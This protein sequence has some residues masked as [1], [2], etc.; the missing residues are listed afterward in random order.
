MIIGLLGGSSPLSKDLVAEFELRGHEVKLFGRRANSEVLGYGSLPGSRCELLINMI[1]GN[2]SPNL[3]GSVGQVLDL[4]NA[5]ILT[6]IKMDLPLIHLSS[7]VVF[8]TN[9]APVGS[10]HPL[11]MPPFQSSYQELKVRIEH[12]HE[13]HR[14]SLQIADLRLF[15]FAGSNFIRNGNY[16]LSDLFSALKKK[17]VFRVQGSNFQRDFTSGSDLVSAVEICVNKSFSGRANLFSAA[18]ISRNEIIEKMV[19]RYSL[20]VSSSREKESTEE[21][22]YCALSENLLPGYDPSTSEYSI[23]RAM[24]E[25]LTQ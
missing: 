15:S 23:I 12:L 11:A 13:R 16:F 4:C 24:D 17:E 22:I 3:V 5:F 19:N 8:G 6:A 9:S 7:G 2:K 14:Q 18:S 25:A 1:G 21:S 20:E 10:S